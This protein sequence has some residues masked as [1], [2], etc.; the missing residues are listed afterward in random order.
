MLLPGGRTASSEPYRKFH[1]LAKTPGGV[2]GRNGMVFCVRKGLQDVSRAGSSG[3]GGAAGASSGVSSWDSPFGAA[4][5]PRRLNRF[6]S[7]FL[8]RL[9][10]LP[11]FSLL[12][13]L[14]PLA[15]KPPCSRISLIIQRKPRPFKC[16]GYWAG[17]SRFRRTTPLCYNPAMPELRGTNMLHAL[18]I[19]LGREKVFQ[20]ILDRVAPRV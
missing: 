7:C 15:T 6:S 20:D 3:P 14:C 16:S 19:D 8:R 18:S 5:F 1:A 12:N 13:A 17:D 11:L 4:N 9:S 2:T 10:S